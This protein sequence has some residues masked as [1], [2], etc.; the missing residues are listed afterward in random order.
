[1]PRTP[2]RRLEQLEQALD[3][4]KLAD[5]Q[6]ACARAGAV[7]GHTGAY[8]LQEF[9]RCLTDPNDHRLDAFEATLTDDERREMQALKGQWRRLLRVQ[10]PPRPHR[11]R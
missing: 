2:H 10:T 3:A 8:L 5:L 9:R 11:P 7:Y 6:D 4:S 1:M